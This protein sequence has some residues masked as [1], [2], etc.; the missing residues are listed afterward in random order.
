MRT[1]KRMRNLTHTIIAMTGWDRIGDLSGGEICSKTEAVAKCVGRKDVV[2][3]D[4]RCASS[5]SKSVRPITPNLACPTRPPHLL[6]SLCSYYPSQLHSRANG[7]H[8]VNIFGQSLHPT[9]H[10]N[11]SHSVPNRHPDTMPLYAVLPA[12]TPSSLASICTE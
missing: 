10:P 8:C 1:L 2:E 4:R 12:R 11:Q 5:E 7:L 9:N 3:R 6:T